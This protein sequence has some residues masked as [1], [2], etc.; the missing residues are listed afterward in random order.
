M[1][2]P[3]VRGRGDSGL[4]TGHFATTIVAQIQ[5]LFGR[6][7]ER[8][9]RM[10]AI[11]WRTSVWRVAGGV[12]IAAVAW[13][14]G[15]LLG[16]DDK[17]APVL[18]SSMF[19]HRRYH[20]FGDHLVGAGLHVLRAVLPFAEMLVVPLALA[21]AIALVV[22]LGPSLAYYSFL[23]EMSAEATPLGTWTVSQYEPVLNASVSREAAPTL[24]HSWVYD[25][26]NVLD[27]LTT[28]MKQCTAH[29]TVEPT[30]RSSS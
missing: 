7:H 14:L 6:A 27:D 15:K 17:S 1:D 12:A 2:R 21:L 18:R 30:P 13:A 28:W 5:L 19:P 9:E 10:S 24:T 11:S 16:I 8:A 20:C 22:P 29:A 23:L 26:R 3:N 4:Q 25:Q